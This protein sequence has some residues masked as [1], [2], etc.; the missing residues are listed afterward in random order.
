MLIDIAGASPKAKKRAKEL[1]NVQAAIRDAFEEQGGSTLVEIGPLILQALSRSQRKEQ[2]SWTMVMQQ[3]RRHLK[4]QAFA[5]KL[6]PANGEALQSPGPGES[7]RQATQSPRSDPARLCKL[8]L[9]HDRNR[10]KTKEK[11][12]GQKQMRWEALLSVRWRFR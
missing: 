12:Q 9:R 6:G 4:I 10:K 3:Q 5:T 7:E 11:T 8:R 2:R 1:D